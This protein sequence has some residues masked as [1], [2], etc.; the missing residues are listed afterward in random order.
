M[1]WS[2]FR[3][4]GKV[5]L[6]LPQSVAH[7]DN[8]PYPLKNI[9]SHNYLFLYELTGAFSLN[10]GKMLYLLFWAFHDNWSSDM[11][12]LVPLWNQSEVLKVK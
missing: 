7:L 5:I 2:Y 11:L 4:K 9:Y 1:D 10:F 12:N 6:T 3:N 8:F